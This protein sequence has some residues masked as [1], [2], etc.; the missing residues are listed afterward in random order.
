[1]ILNVVLSLAFVYKRVRPQTP[2]LGCRLVTHVGSRVQ[3]FVVTQIHHLAHQVRR[4][5]KVHLLYH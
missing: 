4:V 1:M 5:L 3:K 2:Q